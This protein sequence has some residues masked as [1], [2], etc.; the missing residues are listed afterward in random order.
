MDLLN[1]GGDAL[2]CVS[3]AEWRLPFCTGFY[4]NSAVFL[5]FSLEFR[6]QLNGVAAHVLL[7]ELDLGNFF[8]LLIGVA[9]FK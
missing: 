8:Y 5:I 7:S 6:D 4:L 9:V 1:S 2:L 3:E